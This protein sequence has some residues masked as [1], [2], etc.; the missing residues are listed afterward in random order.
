MFQALCR[1]VLVPALSCP[2]ENFRERRLCP[3]EVPIIQ[4]NFPQPQEG[5]GGC[6]IPTGIP[7]EEQS[8]L[9]LGAGPR[10]V[11]LLPG[12]SAKRL[13][14]SSHRHFLPSLP[15]ERGAVLIRGKGR[16]RSSPRQRQAAQKPDRLGG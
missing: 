14:C 6:A 13:E 10:K 3:H 15:G 16:S 7:C 12:D 8:F 1:V 11:S 5:G 4:G 9:Q 2:G